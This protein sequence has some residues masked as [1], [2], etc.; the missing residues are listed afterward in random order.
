MPHTSFGYW[1]ESDDIGLDYFIKT[2]EQKIFGVAIEGNK[3]K[4][5]NARSYDR[6]RKAFDG[7]RIASISPDN[8]P[9]FLQGQR[10]FLEMTAL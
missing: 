3:T 2:E 9:A 5:S 10:A 1:Q 8:F 7:A 6:F 4:R